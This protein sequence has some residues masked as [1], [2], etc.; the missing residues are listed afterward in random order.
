MDDTNKLSEERKL[1]EQLADALAAADLAMAEGG[2]ISC[3]AVRKQIATALAA[4]A[5][6]PPV[7]LPAVVDAEAGRVTLD[8]QTLVSLFTVVL[9]GAYKSVRIANP[10]PDGAEELVRETL[11]QVKR[12]S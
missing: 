1:I 4:K 3:H 2:L 6:T 5:D 12:F 10:D 8:E 7:A 11:A 9:L